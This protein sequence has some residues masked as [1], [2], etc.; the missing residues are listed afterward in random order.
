[1]AMKDIIKN[2]PITVAEVNHWRKQG[3]IDEIP[4]MTAK[5]NAKAAKLLDELDFIRNVPN[6]PDVKIAALIDI[7]IR[8]IEFKND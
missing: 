8:G 5:Y 1:M 3:T 6:D 2:T 7:I 4:L